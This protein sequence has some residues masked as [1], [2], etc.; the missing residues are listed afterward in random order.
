M[1]SKH[2]WLFTL[3]KFAI[4]VAPIINFEIFCVESLF[5]SVIRKKLTSKLSGISLDLLA[6]R[7][8]IGV[9]VSDPLTTFNI[10]VRVLLFSA[11]VH[12][13]NANTIRQRIFID[14]RRQIPRKR[15]IT[16]HVNRNHS[17]LENAPLNRSNRVVRRTCNNLNSS[18]KE[19]FRLEDWKIGKHPK[20]KIVRKTSGMTIC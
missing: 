10:D 12:L 16:P 15:T 17:I 8:T 13:D 19:S 7:R 20:K 5:F 1:L 6:D 18:V 11:I 2:F 4:K 14:T 3:E 9:I